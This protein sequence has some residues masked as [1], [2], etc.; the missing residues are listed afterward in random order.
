MQEFFLL[1]GF[2]LVWVIFASIQDLKSREVA[3][4]LNFSLIIFALGFRFFY[5][6][7]NTSPLNFNFFYQGMIG[8]GIFFVLG[9]LFYYGRIFAGGD[10][11][12][13]MALGSVLGIS[14][15]FTDNLN[16]YSIFL[17]SLFFFGS[18]YGL[19]WSIFLSARNFKQFKKEF[20]I[21]F[22]S[23]K[24][25][26][27]VFTFLAILFLVAGFFASIFL[28]FGFLIFV[29]PYLYIYAKS[30]DESCM[31]KKIKSSELMEGDWISQNIKIG[32]KN[33]KPAWDGLSTREISEIR[34]KYH[35]IKVKEGIPFIPVFL[36]SFFAL[37]IIY[38]FQVD[39]INYLFNLS[40]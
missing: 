6:L 21:Q 38:F 26:F 32:N 39:L 14:N 29:F 17:L 28:F 30:V 25:Y 9:N 31:V 23:N 7:F 4:W 8:L 24:K 18:F 3:N 27:L 20:L 36:F 1:Y 15:S 13:F 11:K 10:A 40:F 33:I 22:S 2:A 16:I 34:K 5:S 37:I 12:L 35:S 19:F